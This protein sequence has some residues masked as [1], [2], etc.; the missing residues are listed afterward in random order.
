MLDEEKLYNETSSV[1]RGSCID[2]LKSLNIILLNTQESSSTEIL[3]GA[4]MAGRL[5]NGGVVFYEAVWLQP[6]H[7]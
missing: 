5:Y 7:F 2:E 4:D 6:A 3:I 1:F